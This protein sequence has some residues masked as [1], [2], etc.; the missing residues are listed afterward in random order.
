M[1]KA[2]KVKRNKAGNVD[3]G[4][5]AMTSKMIKDMQKL[6]ADIG[7]RKIRGTIYITAPSDKTA[8]KSAVR[9]TG[10]VFLNK[11]SPVNVVGNLVSNLGIDPITL[12]L[13]AAQTSNGKK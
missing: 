7:S 3:M 10:C 5:A 4:E 6:V 9:A 8:G 2:K 13:I 1:A 12:M 11:V